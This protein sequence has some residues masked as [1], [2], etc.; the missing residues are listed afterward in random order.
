MN[1]KTHKQ[2]GY[3]VVAPIDRE[4]YTERKGLEGPFRLKSGKIVY[5]D[6]KEGKYY[7]PGTDF[8]MSHEEY[9]EHEKEKKHMKNLF[10][11]EKTAQTL[12]DNISENKGD[13]TSSKSESKP[14]SGL[15]MANT[16]EMANSNNNHNSNKDLIKDIDPTKETEVPETN[17][18]EEY[19]RHN[20]SDNP[21]NSIWHWDGKLLRVKKLGNH[22]D[23]DSFN[24]DIFSKYYEND[25]GGSLHGF[26][27]ADSETV[28]VA[29]DQSSLKSVAN[30]LVRA[31]KTRFG[32][33]KVKYFA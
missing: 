9:L 29:T 15:E 7:D 4:R 14:A 27:D 28:G 11:L 22:S 33:A 19:I 21:N 6:P 24:H 31:L 1:S 8:Y 3:K 32:N 20:L 16:L 26:Y 23:K 18:F 10:N 17:D 2:S 5:Y 25:G 30:T 13:N 12:F